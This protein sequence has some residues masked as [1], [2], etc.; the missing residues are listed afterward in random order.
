MNTQEFVEKSR[1]RRNTGGGNEHQR[2]LPAYDKS[3][4]AERRMET[5]IRINESF[6]E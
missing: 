4:D 3:S 6:S 5:T 1:G 2:N